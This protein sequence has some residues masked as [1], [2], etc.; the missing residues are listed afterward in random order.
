MTAEHF[1]ELYEYH[2]SLNR[3][4]WD[5]LVMPLSKEQFVQDLPYSV[6]SIRNQC[7]HMMNIDDRWFSGLRGEEVPGFANPVHYGTRE[8]IRAEWDGVVE[9][10][11]EYLA[12]LTDEKLETLMGGDEPF[13]GWRVLQHVLLHG[14]DHRAQMLA[15]LNGM[16]VKTWPQDYAL[17]LMGRI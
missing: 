15:M 6:G 14:M 17:R 5:E 4:L 16:G 8:K 11:R 1:R 2:F 7:V 9:K 10:Q 3:K 13:R 12:S